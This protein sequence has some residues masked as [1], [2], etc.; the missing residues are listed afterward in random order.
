MA[1]KLREHREKIKEIEPQIA[2]IN[3]DFI[4]RVEHREK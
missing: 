2:Q 3:T 1:G 4:N